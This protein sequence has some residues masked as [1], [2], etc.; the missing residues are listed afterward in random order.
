MFPRF[1]RDLL[2]TGTITDTDIRAAMEENITAEGEFFISIRYC[3]II[4]YLL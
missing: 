4:E 3:I 2:A 1:N